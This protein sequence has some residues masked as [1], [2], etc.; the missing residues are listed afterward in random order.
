MKN[1]DSFIQEKLIINSK[2]K[3]HHYTCQPKDKAELENILRE[4]LKENKNADLNDI[5]VSQIIDMRNLFTYFDPFNIDISEWDVSNVENMSYMF[6]GCEHFNCDLSQ[7]DVSNVI[8]MTNMFFGCRKF[9]C[10]LSKW[11]ISSVVNMKNMFAFA[12]NIKIPSWYR[13]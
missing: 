10:D 1:I 4:R 5:D 2:S 8:Y 3:L 9:N 7:W 11:D 6:D 13:E 12:K